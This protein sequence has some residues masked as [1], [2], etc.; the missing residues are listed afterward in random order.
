MRKIYCENK[1]V[2]RTVTVEPSR[3]TVTPPPSSSPSDNYTRKFFALPTVDLRFFPIDLVGEIE[4]EG[5]L[6]LPAGPGEL[7]GR[8][9][10]FQFLLGNVLEIN[11]YED[12]F[13]ALSPQDGRFQSGHDL[14]GHKNQ[15]NEP[16]KKIGG[17]IKSEQI[18]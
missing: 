2:E 18:F 3:R 6:F 4:V 10:D 17:L 11:S 9:R 13:G 5:I 12:G 1:T 8:V 15:R 14:W 7:D 16:W